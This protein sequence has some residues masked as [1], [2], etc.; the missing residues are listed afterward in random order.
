MKISGKWMEL[1][2]MQIN[3][4]WIQRDIYGGSL[5]ASGLATCQ[6]TEARKGIW[7]ISSQKLILFQTPRF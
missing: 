4:T 2:N 3:V 5:Q 1:A 7:C 6:S